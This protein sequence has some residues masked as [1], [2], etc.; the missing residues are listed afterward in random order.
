METFVAEILTY[1]MDMYAENIPLMIRIIPPSPI[2][3]RCN[4]INSVLPEGSLEDPVEAEKKR[5]ARLS[6]T[7]FL[8]DPT[9][10]VPEI[11]EKGSRKSH[12]KLSTCCNFVIYKM[13]YL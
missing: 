3:P 4:I 2:L 13:L 12:F 5:Q 7:E 6:L 1:S 11:D 9:N 8:S 10:F